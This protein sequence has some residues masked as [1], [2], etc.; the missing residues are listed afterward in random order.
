[1]SC[2]GSKVATVL[3]SIAL[4]NVL[5]NIF[6]Y[7]AFYLGDMYPG[8]NGQNLWT[9]QA[10]SAAAVRSLELYCNFL[11][12]AAVANRNQIR[13]LQVITLIAMV[14]VWGGRIYDVYGAFLVES[15]IRVGMAIVAAF[16]VFQSCFGLYTIRS[17]MTVLGPENAGNG[18]VRKLLLKSAVRLTFIQFID[19]FELIGK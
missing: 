14:G 8:F 5:H 4:V 11:M 7:T 17:A 9:A 6:A 1:M 3:L 18:Q 19:I 2:G 15:N 13:L 12:V 16:G 10:A